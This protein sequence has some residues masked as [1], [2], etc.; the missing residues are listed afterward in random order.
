MCLPVN[1]I[2]TTWWQEPLTSSAWNSD[3]TTPQRPVAVAAAQVGMFQLF[4]SFFSKP[5]TLGKRMWEKITSLENKKKSIS[6]SSFCYTCCSC[7]FQLGIM[8]E[9]ERAG[10]PFAAQR[11]LPG[12]GPVAELHISRR[13]WWQ[14]AMDPQLKNKKQKK[15]TCFSRILL[16]CPRKKFKHFSSGLW[17][18]NL[19]WTHPLSNVSNYSPWTTAAW[20]GDEA[21]NFLRKF[22]KK[23]RRFRNIS[24]W[25]IY[26]Y[27]YMSYIYIYI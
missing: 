7:F 24:L 25:L 10:A 11:P 22:G 13:F 21:F 23:A 6:M 5:K 2:E 16:G 14:R 1:H 20:F 12:A 4:R 19:H 27:I 18:S 26:I 9:A 8:F 15:N 17:V 3:S